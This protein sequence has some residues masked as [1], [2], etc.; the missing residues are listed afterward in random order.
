MDYKQAWNDTF[1]ETGDID[2]ADN[3][4]YEAA[5]RAIFTRIVPIHDGLDDG[6]KTMECRMCSN[7]LTPLRFKLSGGFCS[8]RCF[9]DK[10][11]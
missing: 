9:R 6:P 1:E 11:Y 4:A 3:A 7:N 8:N 2:Q 5:E 10:Y